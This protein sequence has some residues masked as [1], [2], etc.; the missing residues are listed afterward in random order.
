MLT[1]SNIRLRAFSRGYLDLFWDFT[2]TFEN[3]GDFAIYVQRSEAEFGPYVDISPALVGEQHFRDTTVR[4][5]MSFFDRVY[6]RL[7]VVHAGSN[8]TATYPELG[9]VRLEAR[10]DPATLEMARHT[11][12]RLRESEGREVW[13]FQRKRSGQRCTNC[14][15]WAMSRSLRAD[16][17]V[18]FGTTW[19]GGY[20]TPIRTFVQVLAPQELTQHTPNG[21]VESKVSMGK[22]GNFPEIF[23]NDVLIE[24][25]NIRWKIGGPITKIQKSRSLVRQQAPLNAIPVSDIEYALPLNL[26]IAQSGEIEASPSRNYTRPK[27]VETAA[28]DAAVSFLFGKK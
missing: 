2:A 1:P 8:E 14:F 10:P 22:F 3:V 13:I 17:Q 5:Y 27:N 26:T 15:D 19:V 7:R 20:N 12:L 24:A 9:G 28:L 25:E 23:E 16:C 4:G 11:N 6:Y 21:P 18:C